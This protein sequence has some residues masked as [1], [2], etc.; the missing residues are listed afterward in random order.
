MHE[1]Y[2]ENYFFK[3]LL[4]NCSNTYKLYIINKNELEM[5]DK[6]LIS[7]LL[8]G[9]IIYKD[10][11]YRDT[12]DNELSLGYVDC[13]YKTIEKYNNLFNYLIDQYGYSINSLEDIDGV[14]R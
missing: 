3:L 10:C 12:Y 9:I 5:K 2:R 11:V 6:D 1:P 7:E 4:K 8:D 13:N 14:F